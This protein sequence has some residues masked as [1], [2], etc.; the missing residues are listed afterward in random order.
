MATKATSSD[1]WI[2][3]NALRI[4]L[5]A[6]G[7]P[8]YIQASV[9]S[10]SVVLCYVR[11]IDGLGYD[12]GHNYRRW[13][14]SA[15]PTYLATDTEK[16][17]YVAIPRPSNTNPTARVVYPS[18]EVDIYGCSVDD[19]TVQIGD[20]GYYYI[21]LGARISP[22]VIA[23]V[24]QTE[25]HW[26]DGRGPV[27]GLL[28]TDE[29]DAAEEQEWYR[30]DAVTGITT[31]LK[32]LIQ[33]VGTVRSWWQSIIV[34]AL[35]FG[36]DTLKKVTGIFRSSDAE[37]P[38]ELHDVTVPTEAH[39]RQYTS[40]NYLSRKHSDSAQGTITFLDGVRIPSNGN[41]D[42]ALLFGTHI[43]KGTTGAGVWKDPEGSW[44]AQFDFLRINKK[45]TFQELEVQTMSHIGGAYIQSAAA[46][47]IDHVATTIP[48]SQDSTPSQSGS[49]GFDPDA[50]PPIPPDS[51]RCYFLSTDGDRHISNDWRVCDQAICKTFNLVDADAAPTP[52]ANHY[53]WRVV[54]AVGSLPSLGFHYIDLSLSVADTGSDLPVAGDE[55]I[56]LGSRSGDSARTNAIIQD[57]AGEGSPYTRYYK[58][59][60]S[61]DMPNARID[62]NAEHPRLDVE[63]LTITSSDGHS[64]NVSDALAESFN[65][66]SIDVAALVD[67]TKQ[68]GEQGYFIDPELG[69][70]G[71][72]EQVEGWTVAD[73]PSHI[74]DIAICTNSAY[75]RFGQV[76]GVWGWRNITDQALIEA[77]R[78]AQ[79]AN[80]KAS[81]ALSQLS[82]MADDNII[83]DVE[84][85]RIR[86]ERTRI[87]IER[88]AILTEAASANADARSY[89]TAYLM[90]DAMFAYVLNTAGPVYL[91]DGD[92]ELIVSQRV[93]IGGGVEYVVAYG[94]KGIGG[95]RNYR[96]CLQQYYTALSRLRNRIT[97]GLI[98]FIDNIAIEGGYDAAITS[99]IRDIWQVFG[100]YCED[101]KSDEPQYH[102]IFQLDK[103]VNDMSNWLRD[104]TSASD[105]GSGIITTANY[106]S[107]FSTAIDPVTGQTLAQSLATTYVGYDV[108]RDVDGNPILDDEG[109]PVAKWISGFRI[110]ADQII[111]DTDNFKITPEGDVTVYGILDVKSMQQRFLDVSRIADAGGS[112]E[113]I[114]IDDLQDTSNHYVDEV[115]GEAINTA[116]YYNLVVTGKKVILPVDPK[117]IGQRVVIYD[118]NTYVKGGTSDISHVKI[119]DLN[120]NGVIFSRA[121]RGVGTIKDATQTELWNFDPVYEIEF[122]NGIIELLGV[123]DEDGRCTWAVIN[124]AT[125][126]ARSN[127][128]FLV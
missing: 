8:D 80:D 24:R 93:L 20:D 121:F 51:I 56:L 5:N 98:N 30:Y 15:S 111:I 112:L 13:P 3:P 105:Y 63:R 19:P 79:E 77:I 49:S 46:C 21:Y 70:E 117:F 92:N 2:S 102:S 50:E 120:P 122:V 29:A 118:S 40:D 38:T 17:L 4:T 97:N 72:P 128:K 52:T 23:G 81:E 116:G 42:T 1:Y 114:H 127:G 84:K 14:L 58:G 83:D 60:T 125:R 61:F 35:Y 115:T 103:T 124:I 41:Q 88:D 89:D 101:Q 71:W 64:T 55:V 67:E 68:P 69:D 100:E 107:M 99:Q 73:Y 66:Y 54:T 34:D 25:R 59:I 7:D 96:E 91:V 119:T 62:L 75:F 95:S 48:P 94:T 33:T 76:D 110:K 11:G 31:F 18:Q 12:A 27:F 22:S 53:Y 109:N 106:A 10:D 28:S 86:E 65:I 44:H 123:P 82:D 9:L 43:E 90:L 47:V 85:V 39:M 126:S 57:A 16:W 74:N 113:E 26:V 6:L 87:G 32:P 45:A 36:H 104:P 78:T 37:M 108:E